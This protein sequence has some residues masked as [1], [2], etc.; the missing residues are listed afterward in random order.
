MSAPAP[1]VHASAVLVGR[2]AVLIR[3]PSGSG[4]SRLAAALLDWPQAPFTR[5]VGDDRVILAAAGGRLLARPAAPIAGLLEIR[6]LGLRRLPF[7][8][9]AVVGRVVDLAAADADRLP[10]PQARRC[11]VAGIALPRLPVAAG[12]D[13]LPLVAAWLASA[14]ALD[15]GDATASGP[16][17]CAETPRSAP[18]RLPRTWS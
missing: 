12:C 16:E 10:L 5:L 1:T 6:G 2:H 9:L 11:V 3:G 13:P 17:P 8:P 14:E 4:K 15:Y 18:L 7:E